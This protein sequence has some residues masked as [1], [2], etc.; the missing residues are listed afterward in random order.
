M[1]NLDIYRLI[2][3][4][5]SRFI[6]NLRHADD[7]YCATDQLTLTQAQS[8]PDMIGN[9]GASL[10]SPFDSNGGEENSTAGALE[11]VS[12]NADVYDDATQ[13]DYE[14]DRFASERGDAIEVVSGQSAI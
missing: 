12:P 10:W 8:P 1:S 14:L 6:L 2:T 11:F 3:L 7:E 13:Y 4:L 5:I 9:L